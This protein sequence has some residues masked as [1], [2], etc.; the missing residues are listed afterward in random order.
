MLTGAFRQPSAES[1]SAQLPPGEIHQ[2]WLALKT[3]TKSIKQSPGKAFVAT[4]VASL[5]PGLTRLPV[6]CLRNP[7]ALLTNLAKK[8]PYR[9]ERSSFLLVSQL[10]SLF[11][12][13]QE[14]PSLAPTL[15]LHR[16]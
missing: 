11:L 3:V 9:V 1:E 4:K 12:G 16:L 13:A 2:E 15:A 5:K 14:F 6:T 8:R 7:A 10:L